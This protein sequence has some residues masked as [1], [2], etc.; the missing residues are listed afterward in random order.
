MRKLF[1][2]VALV[3]AIASAA[4]RAEERGAWF[5]EARFGMFIH[6]GLY[7]VPA[8]GE[9]IYARH[10]WKKGEY[11]ALADKLLVMAAILIFVEQNLHVVAD[12]RLAV[13][14]SG[15]IT[16][17]APG[18]CVVQFIIIKGHYLSLP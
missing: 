18:L 3:A 1:V 12:L 11:E 10:P 9:W 14:I 13:L 7:S 16:G 17:V 2:S 5:R 15:K 6:W 8:K 4:A